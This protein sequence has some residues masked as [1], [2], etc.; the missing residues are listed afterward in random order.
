[1]NTIT[2][3][4]V[5][6]TLTLLLIPPTM[7][8]IIGKISREAVEECVERVAIRSGRKGIEKVA[9]KSAGETF[10]QL[11]KR[12]GPELLEAV[13]KCGDDVAALAMKSSPQAR[14]AVARN[15]PELL[16]L[17]RRVGVEALELEAKSPGL[18]TKFFQV[19]GDDSAKAI[20]KS[21]PSEDLP[22]LLKYADAADSPATRKLLPKFYQ[23]E[24]K[25]LFTRIPPELILASGLTASMLYGTHQ[26]T[27]PARAISEAIATN[28]DLA[29]TTIKFGGLYITIIVLF[30]GIL[31]AWRLG[32]MPWQRRCPNNAK[33][34]QAHRY[35]QATEKHRD[36]SKCD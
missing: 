30:G 32:F 31:V 14:R 17:A 20:A 11:G 26:L 5:L 2:Q 34:D 23:Q 25:K 4:I 7:G 35:E 13:P 27:A 1:M 33:T 9:K 12:S 3:K 15:I 6:A 36:S 18:A 19:F 10:E 29:G 22:R 21:I 8:A 28:E 24:G 16:P